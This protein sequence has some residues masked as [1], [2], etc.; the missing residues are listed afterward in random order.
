[1]N[2]SIIILFLWF[3]FT[4]GSFSQCY[5]ISGETYVKAGESYIYAPGY[6]GASW[7]ASVSW[8]V[9]NGKFFSANGNNTFTDYVG[10]ATVI[11]VVWDNIQGKGSLSFSVGS[12]RGFMNNVSIYSV[13][14]A[15]ITDVYYNGNRLSS[16]VI[17]IPKDKSGSFVCK[18]GEVKYPNAPNYGDFPL[19]KQI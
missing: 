4:L 10:T 19:R 1:M 14:D 11:S 5:L 2:K 9:S 8:T 16:D 18:L 3:S 17:E 13:K 7:G 6:S 12:V 15:V